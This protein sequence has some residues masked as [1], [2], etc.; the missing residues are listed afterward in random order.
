MATKALWIAS[1][2]GTFLAVYSYGFLLQ[3]PKKIR[4]LGLG[5]K[6]FGSLSSFLISSHQKCTVCNNNKTQIS[7][8][9]LRNTGS[10]FKTY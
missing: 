6:P 3:M 8:G 10:A 1:K 2:L 9:Q 7:S 4:N 5:D